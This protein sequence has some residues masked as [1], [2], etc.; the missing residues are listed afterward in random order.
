ML[1]QA[2]KL[3][4]TFVTQVALIAAAVVVVRCR[5]CLDGRRGV[6]ICQEFLGDDVFGV[7]SSNLG[8]DCVA[9]KGAGL[10]T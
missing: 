9:V 7:A 2:L 4:E 5:R 6:V 8:E 3:L 10:R 1:V